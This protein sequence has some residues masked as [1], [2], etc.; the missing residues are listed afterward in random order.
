MKTIGICFGATTIQAIKLH[1]DPQFKSVEKML[2]VPHEG[3]PRSALIKLLDDIDT[4]DVDRIAV[5]G[6]NFRSSVV[7]TGI[8]EQGYARYR[9]QRRRGNAVR[10]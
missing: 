9:H 3:N 5:T 7:L 6:R 10:V 4:F 8:H 1:C 2:R